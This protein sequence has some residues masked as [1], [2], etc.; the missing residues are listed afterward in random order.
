MQIYLIISS[1]IISILMGMVYYNNSRTQ[2]SEKK[3][4]AIFKSLDSLIFE[5]NRN[6]IYKDVATT[7]L[8]LLL[9]PAK[10][11][12]GKS[13]KEVFEEK[14]AQQIIDAIQHCIT[15]QELVVMEYPIL[16]NNST[17]WFQGRISYKSN[18]SVIFNA[19]D[20][21]E[22]KR[23][24]EKLEKSEVDLKKLN[25]MKDKFFAVLSHD[26]RNS[27]GSFME[28]VEILISNYNLF[29]EEDKKKKLEVIYNASKEVNGLLE[30]ILEWQI[31]QS[32]SSEIELK[33]NNVHKICEEVIN[34]FK[35]VTNKKQIEII[36]TIPENTVACYHPKL[37][38]AILRNILSNAIKFSHSQGTIKLYC[39]PTTKDNKEYLTICIEDDGIGMHKEKID[40][41][42][43]SK[44]ISSSLGTLSEKGTGLGIFLCKEFVEMQGGQLF[45]DSEVNKGSKFS[46]T[47]KA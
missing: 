45:I 15:T 37:C 30:N 16:L 32:R 42:Y 31:F 46:F 7:K 24:I 19:I 22:N 33:I 44:F 8:S 12:I 6:G 21:T 17:L 38:S 18:D 41:F 20:I 34:Q 27:L 26:L 14:I 3:L 35:L 5:F 28:V 4:K 43:A 47:L 36:N 10:V 23:N 40:Q 9:K 1:F 25:G 11:L 2:R 39:Y 13:V 29:S